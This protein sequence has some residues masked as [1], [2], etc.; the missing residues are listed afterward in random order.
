MY[1]NELLWLTLQEENLYFEI[2][3]GQLFFGIHSPK[4]L[5]RLFLKENLCPH[6]SAST[7]V[8]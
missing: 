2:L 6:I 1:N 5:N 8:V 3:F 7:I 4:M